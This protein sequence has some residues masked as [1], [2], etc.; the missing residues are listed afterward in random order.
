MASSMHVI[1]SNSPKT[2]RRRMSATW[3]STLAPDLLPR[4]VD[5]LGRDVTGGDVE[6]AF[7]EGEEALAGAA[8]DI[9]QAVAGEAVLAR[10]TL[11][12]GKPGSV[13]VLSREEVIGGREHGVRARRI[14]LQGEGH[15]W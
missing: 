15:G 12:G 1:R 4:E 9:E 7:E 10:E 8:P 11:D 5:H 6:A 14:G 13:C 3:T 2:G